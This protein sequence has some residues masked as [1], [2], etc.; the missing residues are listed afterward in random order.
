M[1]VSQDSNTG[2]VVIFVRLLDE[3][4]N[5]LRPVDA[6]HLGNGLFKIM[7]TPNYDPEDE[8]WEHPPGSVVRTERRRNQTGEY[9]LAVKADGAD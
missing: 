6:L 9:L 3:G 2:R 8:K 1:S 4:T 5:V 7:A